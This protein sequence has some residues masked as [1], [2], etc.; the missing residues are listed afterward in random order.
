MIVSNVFL[1]LGRYQAA[2]DEESAVC[3]VATDPSNDM[4]ITGDSNGNISVWDIS[5]YCISRAETIIAQVRVLVKKCSCC[6]D[7]HVPK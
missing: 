7:G 6:V 1:Y 4:L 3:A 5:S 2:D